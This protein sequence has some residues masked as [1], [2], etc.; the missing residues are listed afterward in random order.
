MASTIVDLTTAFIFS[1]CVFPS[2]GYASVPDYEVL[3]NGY[4]IW[5]VVSRIF[6]VHLH[7]SSISKCVFIY[8]VYKEYEGATTAVKTLGSIIITVVA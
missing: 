6:D 8:R 4:T 7:C 5:S 2:V 1:A 3:P